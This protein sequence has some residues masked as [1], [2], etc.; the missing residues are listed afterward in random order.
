MDG[1]DRNRGRWESLKQRLGLKNMKCCGPAAWDYR[2]SSSSSSPDRFSEQNDVVGLQ[3]QQEEELE[4]QAAQQ[5][6][7]RAT[8]R[9]S[10]EFHAPQSAETVSVT[11]C[12]SQVQVSPSRMNLEMALAA[13]RQFRMVTTAP[14]SV[15]EVVGPIA[16]STPPTPYRVSLMRLLAETADGVGDEREREGAGIDKVCCVC[17]ERKKGAAFIPCGHTF[18]RA[19]SRE[20]W[21]SRGTCPLCN[22]LILEIL[23][24]F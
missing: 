8:P 9:S 11:Y 17:M 23:E 21:L 4:E 7:E 13:E 1:V 22:R 10:D 3:V 12:V 18:C 15:D 6:L 16:L 24:I 14:E 2:S 5:Q 20:L 19:C